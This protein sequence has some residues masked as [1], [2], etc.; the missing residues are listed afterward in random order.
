MTPP[1]LPP[2]TS[3]VRGS[4]TSIAPRL[5]LSREDAAEALGVSVDY[6]DEHVRPELRCIRR[7]RRV[8]V[9]YRELERWAERSAS[10]ALEGR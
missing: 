2:G 1:Q 6:F 5:T 3:P 7:G 10:H 4:H 8:L 9:L